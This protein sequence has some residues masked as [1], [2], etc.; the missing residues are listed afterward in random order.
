MKVEIELFLLVSLF[1]ILVAFLKASQLSSIPCWYVLCI[2]CVCGW[3]SWMYNEIK[4]S[5]WPCYSAKIL[6]GILHDFVLDIMLY[7]L[8]IYFVCACFLVDKHLCNIVRL[9]KL[10]HIRDD[11]SPFDILFICCVLIGHAKQYSLRS[12][13]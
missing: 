7:F 5:L 4:L 1:V 8:C 3:S 11:T 10:I 12:F 2:L 6:I 9:E 13:L